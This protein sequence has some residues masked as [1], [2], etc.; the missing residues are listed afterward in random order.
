M[1]G[2]DADV[3]PALAVDRFGSSDVV[4]VVITRSRCDVSPSYSTADPRVV[5]PH[6]D[7]C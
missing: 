3:D 4:D 1:F 7:E 5:V 2:D 6:I